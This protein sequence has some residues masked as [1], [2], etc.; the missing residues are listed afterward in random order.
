MSEPDRRLV[1]AAR[2]AA[3]VRQAALQRR[4]LGIAAA[5]LAEAWCWVE[6]GLLV[7]A[8]LRRRPWLLA[9]PAAL[10]IWWRPRG[11]ARIAA[12]VPLLWRWRAA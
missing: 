8:L 1:L 7:G 9:L 2:R 6:G 3:L 4:Q 10:L 5:P 12:L 11:L